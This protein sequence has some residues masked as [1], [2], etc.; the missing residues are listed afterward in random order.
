MQSKQS[1][2]VTKNY[3][4]ETYMAGIACPAVPLN[5]FI[6][7]CSAIFPW[8]LYIYIKFCL[9]ICNIFIFLVTNQI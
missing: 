1:Q 9:Y 4:E 3:R 7:I 6:A 2:R 5:A 8:Y